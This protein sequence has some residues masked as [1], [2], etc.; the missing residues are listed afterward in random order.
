MSGSKEEFVMR[1]LLMTVMLILT[2]AL[3]Y[4]NVAGGE[5]GTKATIRDSGT[6]M[7]GAIARISP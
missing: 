3:I 2:V 6:G 7:A 5:G 1:Q 4:I